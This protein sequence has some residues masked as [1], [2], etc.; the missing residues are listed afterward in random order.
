MPELA[1]PGHEI[2]CGTI[3]MG[4]S[5]WVLYKIVRSFLHD[6]PCCYIDPKGD[7][8]P[9]AVQAPGIHHVAHLPTL[10]KLDGGTR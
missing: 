6:R 5:Y 4:K 3:G 9:P 2:I 10:G 8:Y 7:T 1:D